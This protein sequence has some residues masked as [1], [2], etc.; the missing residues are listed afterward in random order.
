MIFAD[1]VRRYPFSDKAALCIADF[2]GEFGL[3]SPR[4]QCLRML[5]EVE[6]LGWHANAAFE[7]EF[8]VFDETP[9]SL[10][11][12]RFDGLKHF[13]P[14]NRTYSLGDIGGPCRSS[15]RS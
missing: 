14:A 2:D 1:T 6:K 8:F 15:G 11:T 3:L 4:N 12:K 5:A 7:F 9:E 13:A 10:R